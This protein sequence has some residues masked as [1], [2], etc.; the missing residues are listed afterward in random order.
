MVV[1]NKQAA[2]CSSYIALLAST[3]QAIAFFD[4]IYIVIPLEFFIDNTFALFR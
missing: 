1:M 4:Y 2:R 3:V